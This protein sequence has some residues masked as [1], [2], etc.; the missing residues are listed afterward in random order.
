M[1]RPD[2]LR[3]LA[4]LTLTALL[5]TGCLDATGGPA[6]GPAAAGREGAAASGV[7]AQPEAPE[8]GPLRPATVPAGA[9]PGTIAR[10][11]DGDTVWVETLDAP[12][13]THLPLAPGAAHRIRVLLIDTPETV[14]PG[15]PAECGGAEASRATAALLPL[16]ATVWLLADVSDTD[17]YGRPLRYLWTADGISLG[18]H[19]LE[20]GLAR[21]AHY[22]PDD[23]YLDRYRQIE[24]TARAERSG[25]WGELCPNP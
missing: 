24:A 17:R 6:G 4:G 1:H 18:E 20:R 7:P 22:P 12:D 16:G 2:T 14:H 10:H 9:Q 11:V 21:V 5:L 23:R 13:G 15:R 25:I 3:Q 8:D 19:L